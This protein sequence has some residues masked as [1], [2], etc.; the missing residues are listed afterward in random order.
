MRTVSI[1]LT[2][3]FSKI[4][5]LCKMCVAPV[6]CT[7]LSFIGAHVSLLLNFRSSPFTR[8][9][10]NPSIVFG[11]AP[12]LIELT[13]LKRVLSAVELAL[14]P[15][16]KSGK[17]MAGVCNRIGLCKARADSQMVCDWFHFFHCSLKGV[18]LSDYGSQIY[19]F[20][21]FFLS[22]SVAGGM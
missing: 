9:V 12:S 20:Y 13:S 8:E 7:L 18:L 1:I 5:P 19:R 21:H 4:C 15:F 2:L 10:S 22:L 14:S 11:L 17:K 3:N 6:P 16:G